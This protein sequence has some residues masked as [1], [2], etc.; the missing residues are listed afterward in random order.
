MTGHLQGIVEEMARE[1]VTA[2][3]E[4]RMGDACAMYAENA[5]YISVSTHISGR[6]RIQKHYLDSY[7]DS[8]ARG[9]LSLK[10]VEFAS[11]SRAAPFG[12]AYA[13]F[14]WTLRLKGGAVKSGKAFEAYKREGGRL[15]IDMDVTF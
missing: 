14:E 13:V 3:H 5:R 6:D 7:P 15:V 10:L 12:I 11:G 8:N 9:T 2:W 4:G 1:F